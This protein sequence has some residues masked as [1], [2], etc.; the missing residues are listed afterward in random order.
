MAT[1]WFEKSESLL[2]AGRWGE[3]DDSVGKS[4]L[5][6]AENIV[7]GLVQVLLCFPITVLLI[8]LFAKLDEKQT[9][10][11]L[12]E[13]RVATDRAKLL[14]GI[15]QENPVDI[16]RSIYE[17]EGL[18]RIV[19]REQQKWAG[20][21]GGGKWAKG[22]L[23]GDR[24][25]VEAVEYT[26]GLLRKQLA[27]IREKQREEDHNVLESMLVE[28]SGDVHRSGIIRAVSKE[29][30]ERKRVE[31][32]LVR[33][34]SLDP[35]RQALFLKDRRAIAG[36]KS[37]MKKK[38]YLWIIAEQGG[39]LPDGVGRWTEVRIEGGSALYIL[40]LTYYL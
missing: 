26:L 4:S 29:A 35:V 22:P 1:F 24:A 2:R 30:Q 31:D 39:Y 6:L 20:G 25:N 14:H 3:M 7:E 34:C 13:T 17:C 40:F 16:R 10:R 36:M 38:L 9:A 32:V 21:W 19:K 33:L 28:A 37:H 27:N 23:W 18:L 11:A 5:L 8:R 12:F 15:S